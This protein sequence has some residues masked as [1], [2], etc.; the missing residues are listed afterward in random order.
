MVDIVL[1]QLPI[2][3]VGCP[4]LGLALLKSYLSENGI[5][6]K[7][8]DINAHIY[9]VRGIKYAN[10]WE[11]KH[12][13]DYCNSYDKMLEFYR[14]NRALFLY[15]ID[16]IRQLNPKVVGC[17]CFGASIELTKIFL[18]DLRR[19]FPNF[20]HIIGGPE[21]VAV[22][23]NADDELISKEYIDA[24]CLGEGEVSLVKYFQAIEE[25]NPIP[26]PGVIYKRDGAIIKE[27]PGVHIKKIDELPFPDF[28]DF[29][30]ANYRDSK[31][32]PSY[33][34]R[35]CI[36]K[37]IYCSSRNFM[38]PF[39]FRSGRRMF[40]EVKY[41]KGLYPELKYIRM[42]DDISNGN[43]R[44][45]ESF[46][47][48]MIEANLGLKWDL[49]NAVIRKEMRTPLYR[50]LKR[51]GCTLLGYGMETPSLSLLEKVGKILSKDVDA[52]K[53]LREGKRAGICI[54]VNIM[55]G[56]PGE[57]EEDFDYLLRWLRK[58]R[59]AFDM[60]NPSIIFCEFYPG[61]LVYE[62]PE[63]YAIDLSKGTLF[64]ETYDKTNT[65]PIRMERFERFCRMAE[66]YNLA[67]LFNIQELPN[68]NEMLFR[69]YFV[70]KHYDRAIEY[71]DQIDSKQRTPELTL[72]Y[73]VANN[74]DV[75]DNVKKD[76]PLTDI[77]PYETT[78][79]KTFILASLANNLEGLEKAKL[80]EVLG[81]KGWKRW[82]RSVVHGVIE[83][84]IG[85]DLAEKKI[86]SCYSMMKVIDAKL[87]CYSESNDMS[88]MIYSENQ[89]VHNNES[90]PSHKQFD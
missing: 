67:N 31:V 64:W 45:L 77:L 20:K 22:M 73:H 85:Y 65:Y 81:R 12:G 37:C 53:V 52:A 24:I 38:K 15:Y 39:R 35:G 89:K 56:L 9:S 80:F 2:W 74:E 26:V 44:E 63:K 18:E 72:M 7:V 8:F 71:Y 55:F 90:N 57:T 21:V 41:L 68:K 49:E 5:S 47:D 3:G 82:I 32:L 84:I 69:Y 51:A 13:Y 30:L 4:P 43:I 59:R 62:Q 70:S 34:T 88:G 79:E 19:F 23:N 14:D 36:N 66:K 54:S 17:S 48:L 61:C 29:N 42:A 11:I 25:D 10:Y 78:F 50:K 16:Q 28:S 40:E 60:I 6:A 75:P 83:R 76:A 86:S 33:A 27:A 46:C 1:L 58:N 87:R